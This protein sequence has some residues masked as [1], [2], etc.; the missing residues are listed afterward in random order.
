MMPVKIQ[1]YS[2]SAE[3]ISNDDLENIIIIYGAGTDE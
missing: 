3:E 2:A 1:L